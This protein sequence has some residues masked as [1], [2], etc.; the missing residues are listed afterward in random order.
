[1]CCSGWPGAAWENP[2]VTEQG[3]HRGCASLAAALLAA[4]LLKLRRRRASRLRGRGLRV[5]VTRRRRGGAAW[6]AVSFDVPAERSAEL[7][8]SLA[9][10]VAAALAASG[11]TVGIVGVVAGEAPLLGALA[12]RREVLAESFFRTLVAGGR[13]L[14][15]SVWLA[16]AP[17]LH[18]AQAVR[19]DA[20][21]SGSDKEIEALV[22]AG[23]ASAGLRVDVAPGFPARRTVLSAY[24]PVG[25]LR[26]ALR[27]ARQILRRLPGWDAA[28]N[29][30]ATAPKAMVKTTL[31]R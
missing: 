8:R 5:T 28:R 25:V 24:G 27:Q 26:S 1:M 14:R 3:S 7:A 21:F 29:P 12:P 4:P 20:G 16:L 11:A 30:T 22:A 19:P 9:A 6:L 31:Q 17:G 2:G 13:Q 10:A 23:H 15:P 18:L